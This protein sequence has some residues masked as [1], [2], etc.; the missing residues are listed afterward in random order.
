M[1]DGEKPQTK[2]AKSKPKTLAK[3]RFEMR[4]SK[5]D[6]EAFDLLE[7]KLEMKRSNI[8]RLALQFLAEGFDIE[9]PEGAFGER[10]GGNWTD[11]PRVKESREVMHRMLAAVG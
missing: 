9:L 5:V 4:L 7:E 10:P 11:L 1:S 8:V 2:R 3:D 6:V